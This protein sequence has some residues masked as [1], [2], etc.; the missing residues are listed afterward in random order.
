MNGR[1]LRI[2]IIATLAAGCSCAALNMGE[3]ICTPRCGGSVAVG[4][5]PKAWPVKLFVVW[6]GPGV[7]AYGI[8]GVAGARGVVDCRIV[9]ERLSNDCAFLPRLLEAGHCGNRGRILWREDFAKSTD[10][11][12]GRR[13][14]IMARVLLY[15]RECQEGTGA[16]RLVDECLIDLRQEHPAG[17]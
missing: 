11:G 4:A 12:G 3:P 6:D 15:A 13:R 7:L 14:P 9:L 10:T 5:D 17:E 16:Y 1:A 2:V 8:D